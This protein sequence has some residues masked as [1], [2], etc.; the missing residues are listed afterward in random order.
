[1]EEGGKSYEKIKIFSILSI[2]TIITN[3]IF[4]I[5]SSEVYA[6]VTDVTEGSGVKVNTIVIDHFIILKRTQLLLKH[7]VSQTMQ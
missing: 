2:I 3:I 4:P 1:M 6:G 5:I 7:Q